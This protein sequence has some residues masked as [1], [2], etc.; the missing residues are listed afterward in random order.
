ML[1]RK[2]MLL[3][4][5]RNRDGKSSLGNPSVTCGAYLAAEYIAIIEEERNQ[6]EELLESSE[7]C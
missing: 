6:I 2:N 3:D 4:V 5:E 1:V 7:A